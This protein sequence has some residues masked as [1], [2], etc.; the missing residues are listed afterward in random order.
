MSA[1]VNSDL[2]IMVVDDDPWMLEIVQAALRQLDFHN[3][4]PRLGAEEAWHD[5]PRFQPEIVICNAELQPTDG[6][7]FVRRIREGDDIVPTEV[8]VILLS[9]SPSA[10]V[11]RIA[12]EAGVN[13]L[14]VTPITAK[15]LNER[16]AAL[17]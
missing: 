15:S 4:A 1:T 14:L 3:V 17:A 8:P 7:D 10:E 9:N 12:V 6:L 16:I 13:Q 11:V 2:R 5:L